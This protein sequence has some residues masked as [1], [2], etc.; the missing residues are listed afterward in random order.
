MHKKRHRT[1]DQDL[2]R[3]HEILKGARVPQAVLGMKVKDMEKGCFAGKAKCGPQV[4][5]LVKKHRLDSG[6]ATKLEEAMAMR[7]AMG[8]DIEKDLVQLDEHLQA[9]NAPSKLVSMKLE[10]LRKG[11]NL[12][13]CV[14]AR[15]VAPGN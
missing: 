13:H 14:Y 15:E 11:F 10:S 4:R 3:L 1:W 9:S 5:A 6:A 7:E 2:Q 12:G 8:K